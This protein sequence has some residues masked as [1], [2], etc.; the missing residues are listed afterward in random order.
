MN[1]KVV[2]LL[3]TFKYSVTIPWKALLK[4]TSNSCT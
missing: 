1:E 4:L 2:P 3:E